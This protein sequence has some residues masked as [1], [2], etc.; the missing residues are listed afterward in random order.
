MISGL[1][2]Q[3]QV[4][5]FAGNLHKR[6]PTHSEARLF[7]ESGGTKLP[8]GYYSVV[9]GRKPGV[10][11][12]WV[13]AE[14]EIEGFPNAAHKRFET[15]Y[16]AMRH[17]KANTGVERSNVPVF[18]NHFANFNG[19]EPKPNLPFADEFDRL[20]SSQQWERGSQM[21]RQERVAAMSKEL[22]FQFSQSN[23]RIKKEDTAD[24]PRCE[25]ESKD[26]IKEPST[27]EEHDLRIY[28]N[29]CL[30]VG[31][32]P[33]TTAE[34]CIVELKG[35]PYVNIIDLINARRTQ[36]KPSTFD[37][38]RSFR[39]YTN[40]PGKK[41]DLVFAK[42]DR[43]LS[44][45]LQD[46]RNG[47]R[48]Q[49]ALKDY[50]ES[51]VAGRGALPNNRTVKKVPASK[52]IDRTVQNGRVEKY[53][54]EARQRR[55]RDP[56]MRA[57]ELITTVNADK[58]KWLDIEEKWQVKSENETQN[59]LAALL[60]GE[61]KDEVVEEMEMYKM[62]ESNDE[63]SVDD[64]ATLEKQDWNDEFV[65]HLAQLSE[66]ITNVKSD[67]PEMRN[68]REL[69]VLQKGYDEMCEWLDSQV[70]A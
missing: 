8:Q 53:Q 52:T 57:K 30:E 3:A 44:T 20:A 67:E 43:F 59:E 32:A 15:E 69:K 37:S 62:T 50:A 28:R 2:A 54:P 23:P 27:A 25:S 66:E 55:K 31:K 65:D 38:W 60:K 42:N 4:K 24:N 13:A 14:K 34:D 26:D 5:N 45:L 64:W 35:V 1:E 12:T 61:V 46:M 48:S 9:R 16:E 36:T 40:S 33:R 18:E 70:A 68:I 10:Y 51:S 39:R 19:F 6:F 21:Y 49:K 29:L 56:T 22:Q 58:D 7:A 11:T 17:F 41:V 63:V 47:P